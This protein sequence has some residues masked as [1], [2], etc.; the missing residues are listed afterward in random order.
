[1]IERF[2]QRITEFKSILPFTVSESSKSYDVASISEML[3]K[4]RTLERTLSKV[5]PGEGVTVM[6]QLRKRHAPQLVPT[7]KPNTF[8][9]ASI[10][11]TGQY[12]ERALMHLEQYA[13]A[14]G[15]AGEAFAQL[16]APNSANKRARISQAEGSGDE[17]KASNVI[18]ARADSTD[19]E[20][21]DEDDEDDDEDD[22]DDDEEDDESDDEEDE[23]EDEDDVSD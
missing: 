1:M 19:D 13:E 18:R 23:D 5:V 9:A 11:R 6:E 4:L 12:L 16:A 14:I 21:E 10:N 8:T 20:E 7:G 3:G 15:F 22:D 2:M 17:E